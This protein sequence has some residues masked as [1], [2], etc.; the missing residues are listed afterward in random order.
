[1]ADSGEET[2]EMLTGEGMGGTKHKGGGT[3]FIIYC[4]LR[5]SFL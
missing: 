4:L 5:L 1:M 3:A 2:G